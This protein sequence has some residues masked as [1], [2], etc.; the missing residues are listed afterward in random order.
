MHTPPASVPSSPPPAPT[1]T[2]HPNITLSPILPSHIPSLRHLTARLLPVRYP[3]SFYTPLSDPLSSGAFSR[4]LLWTD[5]PSDAD[6]DGSST[7]KKSTVIGGLVCRP[8]STF[9]ARPGTA[10]DMI[11]DALYIQSL[12]LQEPYRGLGLAAHMLYEICRLAATAADP[13]LRCRTVCAHV[14]TENP[15]GMAWYTARGF[16]RVEPVVPEYYRQLRPGS[17]WIV[18]REIVPGA[19][20]VS[21]ARDSKVLDELLKDAERNGILR[22]KMPSN[23]QEAAASATPPVVGFTQGPPPSASS[24]SSSVPPPP[25]SGPPPRAS[26]VVK[27]PP[28]TSPTLGG[29]TVSKSYQN[30]GPGMEWNDLP[31]DMQVSSRNSS[32]PS[33]AVP[34]DDSGAPSNASSRSSSTVR[35]KRDRAYPAAAFGK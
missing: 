31:A 13:R 6:D 26:S 10:V 25:R 8:A 34:G 15:D 12:V 29:G 7:S 18:R 2:P 21:P 28:K 27:P 11:P 24:S 4:V 32:N 30:S 33:L 17:A 3:D 14:W 22:E 16:T 20:D 1:R 5:N 23:G 9:Q 35:K 19:G